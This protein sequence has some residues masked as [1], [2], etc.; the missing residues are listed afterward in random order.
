MRIILYIVIASLLASCG[1]HRPSRCYN[2]VDTSTHVR[3]DTFE[4]VKVDTTRIKG[5]TIHLTDTIKVD[6][7]N[8]VPKFKSFKKSVKK[9]GAESIVSVDTLGV[10]SVETLC[11]SVM[12]VN[13]TLT[14][15]I[16]TLKEREVVVNKAGE[17]KAS[18][19]RFSFFMLAI[20]MFAQIALTRILKT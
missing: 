20:V 1:L 5:D 8:G 2:Y 4:S 19:W 12:A 9:R 18:R 6:C 14:R 7:I 16:N 10:L 3:V 17:E 13:T 15:E 11:D